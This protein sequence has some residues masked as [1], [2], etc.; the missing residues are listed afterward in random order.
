MGSMRP[1]QG[2]KLQILLQIT[3][4][5]RKDWHLG[6]QQNPVF[7]FLQKPEKLSRQ[8]VS[9][10]PSL[11]DV[12]RL[13]FLLSKLTDKNIHLASLSLTESS[14]TSWAK[15]PPFGLKN[16]LHLKPSGN[17]C[18]IGNLGFARRAMFLLSLIS[19]H[20]MLRMGLLMADGSLLTL[21]QHQHHM[22]IL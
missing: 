17:K 3:L 6:H 16:S 10:L 14:H 21:R 2:A 12:R 9:D 5:F 13:F 19:K 7:W 22:Q 20:E 4:F 18:S 15:T 11:Q 8:Y 1:S